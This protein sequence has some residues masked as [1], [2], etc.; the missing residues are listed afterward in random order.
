MNRYKAESGIIGD[1]YAE[2]PLLDAVIVG[3]DEVFALHTGPT[4]VFFGHCLPTENVFSYA[5]SFG[6]TTYQDI[7]DLHSTAFVRSGIE[8]MK[9]VTVR[10]A[11]SAAVIRQLTGKEPPIVVDPVL[12]YGYKN[13]ISNLPNPAHGNYLLVYAYDNRMNSREEIEAIRDY[14]RSRGLKTLSP[15]FYHDW[16]DYNIDVDPVN[17]LGYFKHATEVVT[18]TFHGSVMSLITG[19][20]FAVKTRNS[21]H[22]K[23]RNLLK[24]YG[25]VQR[26]FQDWNSLSDTMTPE[27]DYVSVNKEIE[28]RR[29]ESMSH[30]DHMLQLVNA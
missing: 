11:N 3:S 13:E 27:I 5:G 24:E 23:L 25:L 1:Y 12:L 26:I 2:S 16:C 18:D 29:S 4:P 14:A 8:S 20:K 7:C 17:L 28:R 21:N 30:L 22:F 6:P 15:G 19:A 10:D 9:Y